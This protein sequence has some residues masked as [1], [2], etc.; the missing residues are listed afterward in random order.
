MSSAIGTKRASSACSA[1]TRPALTSGR[2]SV[3]GA[4]ARK[5]SAISVRESLARTRWA[6]RT[7]PAG[8]RLRPASRYRTICGV[9]SRKAE[10]STQVTPCRNDSST[11]AR[12]SSSS[13]GLWI[14]LQANGSP[15]A[16]R[17]IAASAASILSGTTPAAPNDARNPA[18]AIATT[19]RSEAM[20][21]AI[22]P[23]MYG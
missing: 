9:S 4:G 1:L 22:A 6:I 11:I 5:S 20:P 16:A 3:S 13:F 23:A 12:S 14:R 15:G 19:R 17:R 21:L 7:P 8:S 18:F 2:T 10:A